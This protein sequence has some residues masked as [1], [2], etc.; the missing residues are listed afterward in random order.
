MQAQ[1]PLTLKETPSATSPTAKH[2]SLASTHLDAVRGVAALLVMV[3]HVRAVFFV[4]TPDIAIKGMLPK[5]FYFVTG[6]G[7]SAV[8]VFFVLSGYFISASVFRS[9]EKNRWDWGGY[10]LNRLTRLYVV[11]IP[12]L[13]L[14]VF[15][16]CLG[17]KLFGTLGVY[18]GHRTQ[19]PQPILERETL[20]IGLG[21]LFFLQEIHVPP[22]GGNAALWSL[23]Y[24]FWY[25]L[26]FPLCLLGLLR[27]TPPRMRAL[28]LALAVGTMMF[29][30]KP[31]VM[32]FSIWLMGTG[33]SRAK[34]SSWAGRPAFIL[35]C[36]VVLFLVFFLSKIIVS[37]VWDYVLAVVF[38]CTMYGL[39]N[40]QNR[41]GYSRYRQA[42]HFLSGISY[43][44]YLSHLPIILFLNAMIVGNGMRWQPNARHICLALLISVAL[45]GYA[46]VVWWVAEARTDYLRQ[47]L[48]SGLTRLLPGPVK[49][50]EV[51]SS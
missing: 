46:C 42:S 50:V 51:E 10:A 4:D 12:A 44:L 7:H 35:S 37:S 13:L 9:V 31:V 45:V 36:F 25:Y 29:V 22:F 8:M 47:C 14:T 40:V 6:A 38:S 48:R 43:S 17:M 1:A 23:S 27:G 20:L 24:E 16:D 34:G 33:L 21:N 5:L 11:L 39:L 2:T 30:G 15:W 32:Y 41:P 26:L 3:S 28:Y 19:L 18:G 49:K